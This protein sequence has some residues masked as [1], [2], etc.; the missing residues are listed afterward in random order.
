MGYGE[1]L[2]R[3]LEPLGVYSFQGYSGGELNALGNALD[4]AEE[5]LEAV[6]ADFSY[7][8]AGERGLAD[9]E[10]LFP[11]LPA[12]TLADRQQALMALLKV[13]D[14]SFTKSDIA[15]TLAACGV[16]VSI[17]EKGN[18]K[19]TVTL[20]APLDMDGDPMFQMWLLEQVLPC[21]LVVTCSYTYIDPATGQTAQEQAELSTLRQRTREEWI[22]KLGEPE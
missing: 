17:A 18:M 11:M 6:Q 1:D 15:G 7:A 12:E 2:T 16:P 10:A 9:M 22:A 21:H 4:A 8:T 13:T 3:L 20:E 19:L 14:R 5:Y